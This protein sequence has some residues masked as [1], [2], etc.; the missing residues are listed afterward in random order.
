MDAALSPRS[1]QDAH[2]QLSG[3]LADFSSVPGHATQP[4]RHAASSLGV[5]RAMC[6]H[7]EELSRPE[8]VYNISGGVLRL[9][10]D[11][12]PP[13]SGALGGHVVFPVP[14]QARQLCS[15]ED[16]S[17]AAGSHGIGDRGMSFG[18]TTHAPSTVMAE[19]SS[20]LDS[21]DFGPSEHRGPPALKL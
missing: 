13:L 12:G 16:I 21:M 20:P 11:A 6:Q 18:L 19:I 9:C 5:P 3:R 4:Y 14:F 7:A 8:S 1:K 17:E 2:S 15:L 10:G